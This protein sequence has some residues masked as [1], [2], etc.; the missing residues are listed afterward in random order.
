MADEWVVPEYSRWEDGVI[1]SARCEGSTSG[2]TSID[3][4]MYRVPVILVNEERAVGAGEEMIKLGKILVE[5]EGEGE[6]SLFRALP[7][8]I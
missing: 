7:E 4:Q 8:G 5:L 2:H 3:V 1:G 6:G